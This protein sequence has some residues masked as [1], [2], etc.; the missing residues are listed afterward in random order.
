MRHSFQ[1]CLWIGISVLIMTGLMIS[2]SPATLSWTPDGIITP[3]LAVEYVNNYTEAQRLFAANPQDLAAIIDSI[4]LDFGYIALYSTF[5]ISFALGQWHQCRSRA[6]LTALPLIV[7]AA[8]CD[9]HENRLLLSLLTSVQQ[10][11]PT[12]SVDFTLL[13]LLVVSKFFSLMMV[14]GL[15]VPFFLNYRRR[16]MNTHRVFM[17]TLLVGIGCAFSLWFS[18]WVAPEIVTLC[19]AIGWGILGITAYRMRYPDSLDD[20]STPSPIG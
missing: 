5:L 13:R 9:I 3:I 7:I 12:T 16:F 10:G 20:I 11:A 14:L 4:Y 6:A 15:F 2:V 18:R 17:L 1:L 8:C 19:I